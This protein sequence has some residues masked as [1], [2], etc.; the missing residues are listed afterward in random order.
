MF[1]LADAA[2]FNPVGFLRTTPSLSAEIESR[3]SLAGWVERIAGFDSGHTEAMS[4]SE[5][6]EIARDSAPQDTG[7]ASIAT[8]R[9]QRG[10]TVSIVAD[11]YG[12]E[13]LTGVATRVRAADLTVT[14]D[15]VVLGAVAIHYPRSG[16]RIV[17]QER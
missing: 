10:D 5:A 16:Y 3:P 1:S 9:Y 4:G 13:T 14:R 8:A 15:D 6:L 11:D 17:K 12:L 7:G 2:C